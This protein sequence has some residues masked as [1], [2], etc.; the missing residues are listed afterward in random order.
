MKFLFKIILFL[1]LFSVALSANLPKIDECKSDLYYANGILIQ[2]S[3][4]EAEKIWE[5]K[6]VKLLADSQELRK[7]IYSY[8]V[9]FIK[10]IITVFKFSIANL[11]FQ[12]ALFR[13]ST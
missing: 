8:K 3:K 4:F 12:F 1:S 7:N 5:E 13:I 10:L 2:N 6:A 9:S 11:I